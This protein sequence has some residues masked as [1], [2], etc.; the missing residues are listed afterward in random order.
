[1]T[2]KFVHDIQLHSN[3]GHIMVQA[4]NLEHEICCCH[5]AHM[6]LS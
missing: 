5:M 6:L 4:Q 3:I 1:M 2:L